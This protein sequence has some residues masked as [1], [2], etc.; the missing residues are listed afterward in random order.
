MPATV[1]SVVVALFF[2]LRAVAPARFP[3]SKLEY[4]RAGGAQTAKVPNLSIIN[5]LNVTIL[6][7]YLRTGHFV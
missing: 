7:I 6:L 3:V 2:V 4:A 5:S 1:D